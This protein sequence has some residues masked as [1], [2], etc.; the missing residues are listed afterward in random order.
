MQNTKPT[1]TVDVEYYQRYL[2]DSDLT[3]AQKQELLETLW[4]IVSE[5][6]MMGFDVHPVQQAQQG[7]RKKLQEEKIRKPHPC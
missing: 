1:L 6:V 2:D 7:E 5:F 4:S 3:D